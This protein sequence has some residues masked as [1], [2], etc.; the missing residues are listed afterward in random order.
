MLPMPDLSAWPCFTPISERHP[1]Q[2][3][4]AAGPTVIDVWDG[5]VADDAPARSKPKKG[6]EPVEPEIAPNPNLAKLFGRQP[7]PIDADDVPDTDTDEA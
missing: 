6:G 2:P 5:I 4:A 3:Q 7:A 1:F